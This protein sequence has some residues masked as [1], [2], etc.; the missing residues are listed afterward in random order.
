MMPTFNLA[1]ILLLGAALVN[2]YPNHQLRT[3]SLPA[4]YPNLTACNSIADTLQYSCENTTVVQNSCCSITRGGLVLQPQFWFTWTGLEDQGQLL[5]KGSWTIHGLLAYNCNGSTDGLAYCDL[6]RQYD[7][8]PDTPILPDGTIVAPYTGPGVDTFIKDFGRYDLLDYL[9]TYWVNQGQPNWA[10]WAHEFSKHG[11]CTSTFGLDC[12]GSN[13]KKHEDMINFFDT[14]I[15]AYKMYPTYDILASAGIIPSNKTTYS[16]AQIQGALKAQTGF[17][18]YVGCLQNG[19]VLWE[20]W[21]SHHVLGS[22]QYGHFKIVDTVAPTTCS[23]T[24]PI[25]YYERTPTSERVVG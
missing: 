11:T 25:H 9:N 6:S 1:L 4:T 24:E 21:H 18:P 10:F 13:Y 12:Y 20:I 2:A 15:R 22:E 7:P 14:V 17:T 19:T 16:L 23:S 5:P 8:I 3:T